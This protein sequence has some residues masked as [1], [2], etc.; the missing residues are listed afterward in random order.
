MNAN[1]RMNLEP[2]VPAY[3]PDPRIVAAL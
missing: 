3:A 2:I 1:T